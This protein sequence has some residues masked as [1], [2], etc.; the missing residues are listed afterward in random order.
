MRRWFFLG[1]LSAAALIGACS[2]GDDEPT[3][4]E[5]L[6]SEGQDGASTAGDA[7]L[8][9]LSGPMSPPAGQPIIVLP[10]VD[11]GIEGVA[12]VPFRRIAAPLDTEPGALILEIRRCPE[13]QL[14]EPEI[15][16]RPDGIVVLL[17][18]H[19]HD[20]ECAEALESFVTVHA[21]V[22]PSDQ[23]LDGSAEP[24]RPCWSRTRR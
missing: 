14:L 16:R 1:M 21:G 12:A 15:E 4:S 22:E 7:A 11:T 19:E 18:V 10:R 6:E 23:V 13:E 17:Q 24:A 3:G 20:A 5:Q 2:G 9:P 8:P